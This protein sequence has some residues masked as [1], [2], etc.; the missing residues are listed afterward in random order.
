[1]EIA[2]VR[3]REI[4]RHAYPARADHVDRRFWEREYEKAKKMP[5]LAFVLWSFV[6]MLLLIATGEVEKERKQWSQ[7]MNA[8]VLAKTWWNSI[9]IWI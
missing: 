5:C 3:S 6:S 8:V 4:K 9:E 1:M 2:K 7:T